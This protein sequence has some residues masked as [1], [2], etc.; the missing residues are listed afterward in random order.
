MAWCTFSSDDYGCDL[1]LAALTK[2]FTINTAWQRVAG[3]I[4]KT[5]HL[6]GEGLE[7]E[8]EEAD[9]RQIAFLKTADRE[10]IGLPQAGEEFVFEEFEDFVQKVKELVDLGYRIPDDVGAELGLSSHRPR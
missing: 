1:R 5:E 4:P 6:Q 2:G 8:L 7:L 10:P 9:R 3:D